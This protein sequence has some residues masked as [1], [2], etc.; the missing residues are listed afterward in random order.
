MFRRGDVS[1]AAECRGPSGCHRCHGKLDLLWSNASTAIVPAIVDMSEDEWTA[2]SSQPRGPPAGQ[3]GSRADGRTG[4]GTMMARVHL[5]LRRDS[6]VVRLLCHQGGVLSSARR[7][8]SSTRTGASACNCLCPGST[9]RH[10]CSWTSA[11][12]ASRTRRRPARTRPTPAGPVGLSRRDRQGR[13]VPVVRGSS[14]VR[15][16]ALLVDGGFTAQ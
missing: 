12:G 3:T 2:W 1:V 5:E 4:G 14:F 6:D 13:A 8:P 10:W 16:E 7:L 11:A 15:G 9:A